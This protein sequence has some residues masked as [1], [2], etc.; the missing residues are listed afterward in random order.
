MRPR[1]ILHHA[2]FAVMLLKHACVFVHIVVNGIN[3]NVAFMMLRL[4][5]D[6][7]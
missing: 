1:W 6:E 7:F 5:A 2:T 3:V 4:V